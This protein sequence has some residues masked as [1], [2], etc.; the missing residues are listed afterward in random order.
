MNVVMSEVKIG[1]Q[2][3][4]KICLKNDKGMEVECLNLG[5]IITKINVPDREGKVENVVLAY[6]DLNVYAENPG[7]LGAIIGRTA[8]RIHKG[9]ITLNNITYPLG[10]NNDQKGNTLHGGIS[11]F[12]KKIWDVEPFED[13]DQVG[14]HLHAISED[15]EEGYPGCVRITVTY[16]L[17]EDNTFEI[18]YYG[19]SDKD[20]LLNMTNHSYFNLSGN[21]KTPV[22]TQMLTVESDSVTELDAQNIA[23]GHLLSVEE[24]TALNFKKEKCIGQDIEADIL[25][26][27]GGYDHAWKL[28]KGHQ[29]DAKLRDE[30]SGRCMSVVT[31]CEAVVIYSLNFPNDYLL[32]NK[33]V[34]A[35]RGGICFET[36][37]L[38]IGYNE[39]FKESSLLRAQEPYKA[40]TQFKFTIE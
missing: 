10:K 32:D 20:T 28:N 40:A 16:V 21:A 26:L 5:G 18:A 11:G 8:G 23:T 2:V 12:D 9:Q 3:V 27:Q 13:F 38:P 4:K 34:M 33:K 25:T 36:Q 31:S 30:A 17:K 15:G 37:S 29:V 35:H 7:Y 1:G 39:C 22:T 24:H 6:D 14:V 19:V